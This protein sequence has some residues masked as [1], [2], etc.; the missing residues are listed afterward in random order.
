[1][2]AR[3]AFRTGLVA[4]VAAVGWPLLAAEPAP[5]GRWEPGVELKLPEKFHPQVQALSADGLIAVGGHEAGPAGM[6]ET[7][8][9]LL[10]DSRTGQ[11]KSRWPLG[12]GK[13]VHRLQFTADGKR[14]GI[15]T[16]GQF[17]MPNQPNRPWT[18]EVWDPGRQRQLYRL[19]LRWG[20]GPDLADS[21]SFS[22]DGKLLVVSELE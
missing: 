13:T 20:L 15:G 19:N 9:V 18:L 12:P 10:F 14:L 4:L 21:W 7:A 22:P 8:V 1:M 17:P 16:G 6:A 2:A 11:M 3:Q 5:E